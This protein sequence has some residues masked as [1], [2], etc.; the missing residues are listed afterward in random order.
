MFHRKT[1]ILGTKLNALHIIDQHTQIEV[2]LGHVVLLIYTFDYI[3]FYFFRDKALFYI[4]NFSEDIDLIMIAKDQKREKTNL[5]YIIK[6]TSSNL[7]DWLVI[8]H[9]YLHNWIVDCKMSKEGL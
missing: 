4:G 1:L 8:Q 6:M 2:A 7:Y 3:E 5:Q 9:I